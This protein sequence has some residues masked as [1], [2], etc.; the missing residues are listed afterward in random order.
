MVKIIWKLFIGILLF[1]AGILVSWNFF[2]AKPQQAEISSQIVVNRIEEVC[3]MVTV[4]GFF[5]EEVEYKEESDFSSYMDYLLIKNYLPVTARLKVNATVLV[6]FDMNNIKID[7][8]EEERRIVVSN[9]PD[10][11][12]LSVDHEIAYFE[13]DEWRFFSELDESDY[14]YLNKEAEAKIR[15]AA[16]SSD[17]MVAANKNGNRMVDMMRFIAESSGWTFEV[18][19]LDSLNQQNFDTLESKE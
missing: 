4:E 5:S 19:G 17:L 1:G 13:K 14:I 7:A 8:F 2:N 11:E 9:I 16:Q 12:I 15:A 18:V 6:G 3:K 10:A